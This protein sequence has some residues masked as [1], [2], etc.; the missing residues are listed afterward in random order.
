MNAFVFI[1][2]D[3]I[4]RVPQKRKDNKMELTRQF[5][6]MK[7]YLDSF[8]DGLVSRK[9]TEFKS[10]RFFFGD[11]DPAFKAFDDSSSE[12]LYCSLQSASLDE[13]TV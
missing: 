2:F 6:A 3:G 1:I 9:V 8:T 7:E 5:S 4:I 13:P 10:A 12:P 11:A